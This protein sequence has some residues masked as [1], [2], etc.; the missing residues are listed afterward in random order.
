MGNPAIDTLRAKAFN[1]SEID[2]A[3]LAHDLLASLDGTPDSGAAQAW[4]TEILRRLDQVDNGTARLI[5]R[6]GLRRRMRTRMA[7]T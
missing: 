5:D 2:R 1:L 4:E 7:G 6:E 3:E